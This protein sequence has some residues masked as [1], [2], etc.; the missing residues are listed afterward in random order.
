[1]PIGTRSIRIDTE[2]FDETQEALTSKLATGGSLAKSASGLAL[3][4]DATGFSNNLATTDTTFQLIA[5]KLDALST[6]GGLT[7]Q[8][9]AAGTTELLAANNGYVVDG[10]TGA[11]PTTLS[12]PASATAGSQIA[13]YYNSA[14]TNEILI[15]RNGRLVDGQADSN[16]Y[17]MLEAG[18][19]I[20][21]TNV[22]GLNWVSSPRFNPQQVVRVSTGIVS[23]TAGGFRTVNFNSLDSSTT[24]M[25]GRSAATGF[26]TAARAAWWEIRVNLGFRLTAN[27]PDPSRFQTRLVNTR[28]V[29]GLLTY[30]E[31]QSWFVGPLSA[32][33]TSAARLAVSYVVPV[34]VDDTISIQVLGETDFQLVG[35]GSDDGVYVSAIE[36][37]Y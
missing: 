11:T 3:D 37:P 4:L 18:D 21:F 33:F 2:S 35:N 15:N 12:L 31:Q 22:D 8:T 19:S 17:T 9:L 24:G 1:M 34:E 6:G 14:G 26:I 29:G 27:T 30:R 20:L 36:R 23:E 16:W 13:V 7:W 32:P 25:S 5:N 10:Q 28:G